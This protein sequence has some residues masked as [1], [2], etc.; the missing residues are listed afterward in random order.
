VF[1]V[2]RISGHSV[3]QDG[4]A[5]DDNQLE[6]RQRIEW[7]R[8]FARR[9]NWELEPNR[10]S[11]AVDAHRQSGKPLLDLSVSNP[12]ECAFAYDH[13][14]ILRALAQP[15]ALNYSP[16][17]K[18]MLSARHAV[19]EYYNGTVEPERIV[20]T[21]S[22]SEGYSF[23]FRLLCEPGDQ[24]LVPTP[25]YPL[26][27]FLANIQDVELIPYELIYDHGWHI[28][29]QS[30]IRSV[31]EKTRALIVVHPNNPTGSYVSD[32]E[33]AEL[34][35]LCADWKMAIV[36]DEVF[37]D[38]AHDG[39]A[40][41][42]FSRNRQALTFALSGL[43][44][45]A[46]LPQMKAAWIA[47][48]GPDDLV[49]EALARLEVIADTYLSVS[50]PVQ[51]ALPELLKHRIAMQQQIASRVK[52]NLSELDSQLVS[53]RACTRLEAE[54]GWYAVLRIPA[55][56][57]DEE[58]AVCMLEQQNVLVHPGHFYDFPAD[59]YLVVSLIAPEVDFADGI[60]RILSS[61]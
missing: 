56:E 29:K 45:I 14:A 10:L 51:L 1:W 50:T 22:T 11:K 48:S 20:L 59:G 39:Q 41:S 43:S 33:R 42:S 18:G 4:L 7:L 12:T 36:A 47:A 57:P 55:V 5:R 31:T 2:D 37:L 38:F 8:M 58:V 21:A 16:T 27:E 26:F 28:D 3:A 44:K 49:N 54:G 34:Q 9:T 15:E 52:A 19:G 60:R 6:R 25:S 17:A 30:L 23:L 40:R 46:A 24:V 53:A 35:A 32:N 61:F 13:G